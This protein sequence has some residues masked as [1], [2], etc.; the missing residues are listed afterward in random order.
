VRLED[1]RSL[2]DQLERKLEEFDRTLEGEP[3]TIDRARAE[4]LETLA[5]YAH[6]LAAELA[7]WLHNDPASMLASALLVKAEERSRRTWDSRFAWAAADGRQ[8]GEHHLVELRRLLGLTEPA[9][10]ITDTAVALQKESRKWQAASE[11]PSL[12]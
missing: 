7:E 12:A 3:R 5:R 4:Y 9:R 1:V 6:L 8:M 10:P 2:L 11:N